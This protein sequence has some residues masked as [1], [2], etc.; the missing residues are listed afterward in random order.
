MEGSIFQLEL[1]FFGLTP[2]YRAS[3]FTQLHD[4]V[5]HGKGGYSF[6]EIYEFPIWLRRYVHRSMIEFYEN[7][8]KQAQKSQGQQSL[9]QDGKIKAPDYSTKASR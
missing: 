9:L 4:I 2:E 3:L 1:P 6:G 5:F 8:N 7:E